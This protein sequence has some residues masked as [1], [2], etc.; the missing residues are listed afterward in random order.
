MPKSAPKSA[1]AIQRLLEERQQIHRWLER[2]DMAG[3]AAPEPVRLRVRQDYEKR[4]SVVMAELQGYREEL[5][6]TLVRQ[7]AVRAGLQRQ[8]SEAAE[9][10]AEAEL[11]HAVGEYTEA[12]WRELHA[13][14]L[15]VLVKIREELKHADEE[16]AR[17]NE[18]VAIL[19]ARGPERKEISAPAMPASATTERQG[20]T[21]EPTPKK[22]RVNRSRA[23]PE[24]TDA[25]DELAFLRAVAGEETATPDSGEA[26][27]TAGSQKGQGA[28]E[29]RGGEP[30]PE[31]V[32][33]VHDAPPSVPRA[34]KAIKTLKCGECGTMNLPTEWYCERC[35]AELAAL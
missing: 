25:L 13:E 27:P 9:R 14:L 34:S 10:L 7:Q 19:E 23:V 30:T 28:D 5:A 20:A 11:R 29:G 26:V 2:L 18:V 32:E 15:G 17:L 4:L 24:Q 35:G 22:E 8:E 31:K 3:D 16:I 21:K 12:Q 6:E 1:A 33:A